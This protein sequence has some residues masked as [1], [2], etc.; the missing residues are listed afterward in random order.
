MG[1]SRFEVL[2]YWGLMDAEYAQE[3]GIDLP[4]EVDILDEV[5]INAWI[6]NGLYSGLLLI[7]LPHTAFPTTL[8]HTRE[9]HIV[10]LA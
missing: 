8:F 9:T 3:V 4:E 7:P 6:C 1:A 2:E 5:Q 10:S